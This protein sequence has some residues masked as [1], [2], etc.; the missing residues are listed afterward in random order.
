MNRDLAAYIQASKATDS[1]DYASLIR[2]ALHEVARLDQQV[3]AP[4]ETQIES[5]RDNKRQ[6]CL[7]GFEKDKK[8]GDLSYGHQSKSLKTKLDAQTE[9]INTEYERKLAILSRETRQKNELIRKNH[10]TREKEAKSAHQEKVM[11]AEFVTDGTLN[12]T[13]KQQKG[14]KADAKTEHARLDALDKQAKSLLKL[15]RQPSPAAPE[16]AEDRQSLPEPQ[17][18]SG[19]HLA[20][21]EQTFRRLERLFCA[22]LFVGMYPVIFTGGC[23]GIALVIATLLHHWGGAGLPSMLV[24]GIVAASM[25]LLISVV[26]GV[27]LW[28][29]AKRRVALIYAQ[30]QKH[31]AD[32]RNVF[33]QKYE[34]LHIE[35]NDQYHTELEEKGSE[36][37]KAQDEYQIRQADILAQSKRSL[38]EVTQTYQKGLGQLK[39]QRDKSLQEIMQ[40][41][42]QQ[43]ILLKQ[44]HQDELN[45]A[46]TRRDQVL[47]QTKDTY[48]ENRRS[49]ETCWERGVA[50]VEG[51]LK[52]SDALDTRLLKELPDLLKGR[53][54][55]PTTPLAHIRFGTLELTLDQ[56][57]SAVKAYAGSR[58]NTQQSYTLPAVLAFP[59]QCSLLLEHERA[60][61]DRAIE[62]LRAVM[63]RLFTTLPPGQV[64]LTLF[65]P[66]GL[67]E[68]FAGFMHAGD[69]QDTLVG[70]RIWTEV[71]QI[72]TQL[73]DITQHMENVIQK[74][75]R[76]EFDTIEEYNEQ[77][78][79]L[80]EPYR[81]LVFADFPTHINEESAQR[82]SSIMHSGP[83]C[84][85][86]TLIA[87]DARQD[88]PSTIDREDLY[89]KSIHLIYDDTRCTLQDRTLQPFELTLD[90]M[91]TEQVLTRTMRK[92]GKAGVDAGKVE[93]P[94]DIIAP[95]A[96]QLGSLNS[97]TDLSLPIGRTGATRLQH[98]RLGEGVTQ[99]VLIAG[100]TGSGKSTLF[101]VIITNLALWYGPDQVELY[102][103]DFKKGVEFKTYVTNTLPHARAIAIESDREFGLSILQRLSSEMTQRGELFRDAGVQ[104][105]SAY[106][107]VDER[108]MPRTVLIVDE[109]QV[110]FSEDDKIAQDAA[111]LLEQLVRQGRAFGIHV[112]LGSQTLGGAFG[113]A[114][115]TMGQMAVRIALQC[116]E[117]D[118]QLILDD[119]NVAARLLARPGD[120]IYNDASGAVVGNSPF[121]IAWL[122][123]ETRDRYLAKL[124]PASAKQTSEQKHMIV[125]E[126]SQPAQLSQNRQLMTRLQSKPTPQ[127]GFAPSLWL[128]SPV[129][130]K[131]HVSIRLRRQSGSNLL[132]VGQREDIAINLMSA[133]FISLATQLT[134]TQARFILFDGS[135]ADSPSKGAL[136]GIA[137]QLPHD[138]QNV[139]IRSVNGAINDCAQ[140]LNRRVE[141]NFN[142]EPAFF[143]FIHAIQRYRILRRQEDSFGFST[144]EEPAAPRPDAQ[145]TELL[146]EG[147]SVGIHLLVW[148]D[149]L[150]TVERTCDR[151]TQRE[152]DNRVLFQMSATD[153]SN[154]I[155]SPAANQLGFHRALLYSEEQ[156]GY[157]KFCPYDTP[158]KKWLSQLTKQLPQK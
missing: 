76:N 58:L 127:E 63:V 3:I 29:Q 25:G 141:G 30:F 143:L 70:G 150:A 88:L 79:E 107:N 128:G 57:A 52:A 44:E 65:D 56:L 101:H 26:L 42:Q 96:K 115:S 152:F 68:N 97:R 37:K 41:A 36:L 94:F 117:A 75:L 48:T 62:T 82:L 142:S 47:A 87:I 5:E 147:P 53:W 8:A 38:T 103:I 39:K 84:G 139:A 55:P 116:S 134:P 137:E 7:D 61:R 54:I 83:R 158:D 132:M 23:M 16:T 120:A 67:G 144:S 9:T 90:T 92:V 15:Y 34:L 102:L 133:A 1:Q 64:R 119:D 51:L 10:E 151:H 123:D 19:E 66:V 60:G 99:H 106:R 126:G 72:Q 154:L 17:T 27:V 32:A 100:K 31:L 146:R 18:D 49:L 24:T 121:Q 86:H 20:A 118:S 59:S 148:A 114:R 28:Q 11:L 113:L 149:T 4:L 46:Q 130:I 95:K 77:A 124:T 73:E 22:R 155:D 157:E 45:Q 12:K 43:Q 33:E 122:S 136:K 109:F 2:S 78:G 91:P 89:S 85:V 14:A 69:Y 40:D 156:G 110:F 129:A 81:F 35:L 112:I 153:S 71:S 131:P 108:S 21:T 125:F 104:D 13:K 111:V 145:L 80:A 6:T 74:Y 105:I 138:H 93:V 140:E 98:L 50:C 135:S